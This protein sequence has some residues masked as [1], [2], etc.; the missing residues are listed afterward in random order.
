V[1][2]RAKPS[3]LGRLR[4]LWIFIVIL[5][6]AGAFSGFRVATWP[7]F[8]PKSVSVS[9]TSHVTTADVLKRAAIASDRNIWLIDKRAA[10]TRVD[11]LPWVQ[12]TRIHRSLPANVRVV[13]I[14]RTPAAC[15][16]AGSSRYLVDASGHVIETSCSDAPRA[17]V[18]GWPSLAPQHPGSIVDVA[19]L[20]R[21]LGDV[22]MLRAHHVDP[23]YSGFDRFGGL[24]VTLQGGIA[25]RFGD[26][27][28][29][30]QKAALVDPILQAYGKRTR[31]VAVIDLRAP[32]TP[33][34]EERRLNR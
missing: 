22:Q 28:D 27:R 7:G 9:G 24:E 3:L 11:A 29:L 14:E 31:D 20:T 16:Q 8:N 4:V 15:L 34:V 5:L 19:Q 33:V 21:S 1:R 18:I 25:V 10:E 26:D 32:A 17:V 30:A 13:V 12:E 6:V 23:V 2:R